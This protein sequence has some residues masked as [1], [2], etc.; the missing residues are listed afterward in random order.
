MEAAA[1]SGASAEANGR[2]FRGYRTKRYK[3]GSAAV[4]E[5]W[6]SPEAHQKELEYKRRHNAAY[7][8][9]NKE[10]ILRKTNQ[11]KKDNPSKFAAHRRKYLRNSPKARIAN[12]ARDR[13]RRMIGSQGKGRGRS[14]KLIGCDANTLCLILEAQFIPGMTWENYGSAW[15]VDHIIPVS[16]YDLTDPAQQR[17]AFHYTN[18]QPL[19]ASANMAKS[20]T[21]EGEDVVLGMLAA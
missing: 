8:Q 4:C 20:D 18:L 5:R 9:A 6:I 19:W 2:V 21:V 10:R 15:H 7:Y 16:V 13:I 14:N 17:Q 3:D 1:H 12:N 11:W